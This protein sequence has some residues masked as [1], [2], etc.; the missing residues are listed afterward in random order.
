MYNVLNDLE[1]KK[2]LVIMK[3]AGD[4]AF[5]AGGDVRSLSEGPLQRSKDIGRYT[6]KNFELVSTYKKPYVA[7]MDGITMGG[8]S[9][10]TIAGRYRVATER[11][12]YAM[13]ETALGFFNDAGASYFLSRLRMNI[14]V[15]MGLTGARLKGFDVKKV[16]LATHFVESRRLDD[17]EKALIACKSEEEVGKIIA[18]HASFPDSTETELD[19][20]LPEIDKCF[21]GDTVDEIYENLHLDGSDWAMDT[22]RT[23]NKMSPT[24]LKVS[25]RSIT[26]GKKMSLEECLKMEYRLMI[27][28]MIDSDLKEGVRAILIDKDQKPNWNPKSLHDVTNKHVDRFFQPTPDGDELTFERR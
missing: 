19:G 5:S 13:P 16:G 4:R 14:G 8:A 1:S 24:S 28:H 2:S 15:Y 25:H 11:T 12:I 18:K 23:L 10:F 17:L 9:P 26:A 21:D 6:L 3:G 20:I 22:I 7:I 27:N